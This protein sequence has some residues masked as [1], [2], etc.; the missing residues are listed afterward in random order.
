MP[1]AAIMP[2]FAIFETPLAAVAVIAGSA[3]IPIIIHLLNRKRFRI[4]TWAAM[5]FL[6]AAQKKNTRRMRIEQLVLLAV[7]TLI[8]LLLVCAMA[9]VMPWSESLWARLF[10][11]SAVRAAA[12]GRRT[13][14]ILVL[15]GSFS[16]AARVGDSTCFERARSAA[17]KLLQEAPAG[18]GFSVV[19]M[20]APPRRV[21]PEP[22][23]DARKA[24]EEVRALRLPHGNADLAAT[25]SA[26][27][28][29]VRHSPVKFEDREVYF[30]T[31]AQRSTW[32]ARQSGNTA[33]LL[34]KIQSRARTIL[35]DVGVEGLSNVAVTNLILGVPY[36]TTGAATPITAALHNYGSEVRGQLRVDLYIGKARA[37]ATD[38][39]F[40]FQLV[41]QSNV[42]LQPG[43]SAVNFNYQFTTPGD[44]ALQ[45]RLEN[46]ALELDDTRSVI[47][48]VKESVPVMLVNGK[49]ASELYDRATEWLFD[50]LNPFPSA[51]TPRNVPARPRTVTE[52]Q[53]ADA[54]LGDLSP[55][56]CVFLCDVP[57]LGAPEVR[58]LETHL[59]RG[60]GVVFCLGPRVDLESYNRL[61]YRNGEGI[62][63]ARLLGKQQA[64]DKRFFNFFAE[65]KTYHEPPL[66]A[67]AGER[68]RLSLLGARFTQYMRAELPSRGRARK[69]LSFMPEVSSASASAM[70]RGNG[71]PL[72]LG[73]P[74]VVEWSRYR[75]RVLLFTSTVNMDWTTWPISPS[76]PAMMQEL[77][78]FAVAG[79]LRE[80]AAVVGEPLRDFPQSAGAGLDVTVHTPEGRTETAHT[81]AHE[82]I[83]VLNWTDTDVSGV[84]RITI[85]QHP[86][87]YLFAV[88]V[89]TT[90]EVQSA[91]ES[92]L[93]RTNQ[94]ELQSAYPGWEFQLVT[95]LRDVVHTGGPA[96]E[97]SADRPLRGMGMI[98]ARWM[99]LIMVLL[100]VAEVVLAWRFG[101]YSAVNM[102]DQPPARGRLVPIAVAVV[103]GILFMAL[104]SVLAHAAWTGDFLSF[105]PEG[106]RASFEERLGIP[107][108]AAGEGTRWQ[109]EFTP[110]LWDAATDPWLAGGFALIMAIAII[111]IYRRE[112]Q[113]ANLVY[114]LLLG[115]LRMFFLLLTLAVLLPQ[116][117]L[118]F[119]REGW[120]DIAIVIDDSQSMS[121]TDRYQDARLQE[122]ATRLF[123]DFT[124]DLSAGLTPGATTAQRL[125]LAQAVLTNN[126]LEWLE[127]LL[128]H[129]RFKLH[130]YHCASR[131][132]RLADATEAHEL[133]AV[134][135]AIRQLRAEGDSSQLGTAVR[136]VLNDFRGSSLA[137]VIMFTDGVTTDGEDLLRV[138]HYATQ[139]G[140]PLFFVGIGD[141]H[142]TRDLKL[143]DVQVEDSVYV[144]DKLVFE[145]RVT[146]QGYSD[147]R[148]IP[149]ALFEK[150]K[151]G[152]LRPLARE[153]VA[154]DREGKPVKFR[155]I[156]QP[157]EPGE[158]TYVLAVPE[159]EDEVKPADNNRLERTVFV[160]EAK[161][162]KVLYIEGYARYEYR[163][164]KNL[165][166][167]ESDRDKKNKT[168]DLKVLLL[169][170]DDGYAAED[171]SAIPFFPIKEELNL[172]DV[173]IL[174]DVDPKDPKMGEKN[175][176]HLAAFV[177]E[178]GGGFLMIAGPRYTP[179][180]YKDSPLRDIMPIQVSADV[181]PD[182]D[183]QN[184]FRPEPTVV[185]RFHPIFRFSP[186]EAENTAIWKHLSEICWW[187]EGYRVQ[188]AAEVLLV[189]P[190]RPALDPRPTA[191]GEAGHPLLVQQFVGA[192]RS[193]FF[194]F[195]ETWRWRFREDE[196]RFNQFWIQTVR[197]LARSRLGRIDLRVDRQT[198]YRRGEPIKVSV[199][200]PDDVPPPAA[201]TKVE[202]VVTRTPIKRGDSAVPGELEKATLHLAKV[203]GSRATYEG[204]ITRTPEGEYHF[205]LA[206]PLVPDP[207]PRAE[208]RVLPPP[209]EMDLLRMNQPDM[210]RAAEETQGKF[211]TLADAD[212]L[213]DDLPSGTRITLSTPQP[214]RLLWNHAA[215]FALA[216]GLLSTEWLLRKRKHLL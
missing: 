52:S 64:P 95:D 155:L 28:D 55:Y 85:G 61:L 79:R 140:V 127:N 26:V 6:L 182:G 14:K 60:G 215:M 107:P 21:V 32:T 196:L 210:E 161:L 110:Y 111:V 132:A 9:S 186:D 172:F 204:L 88:N 59:H 97:V 69:I 167:R 156:H 198:P 131:A 200:F 16:M 175:L 18:D 37:G 144:N 199:R 151:A 158:K 57:R 211:Y 41:G 17:N 5:R 181:Q 51:Q 188:P 1:F 92:D 148:V 177:K 146:A 113:T 75:G 214:P 2:L 192:G 194:G 191:T 31:D 209:G 27:E 195:D 147:G 82:D 58:R 124:R 165:L 208:C 180:A 162:I 169:D 54:A 171:R 126:K 73:D 141:A 81:E 108:P 193:M 8:V 33:E 101:H 166:E 138:S 70:E 66:D 159:Q 201:D 72:P 118:L 176:Q 47:V 90:T 203:E 49:P 212:R 109:L 139:M 67:F 119:E 53:F 213:V 39:P 170:A 86:Q 71:L 78:H 83:G 23:D 112:G 43:Q 129:R 114:K 116:L 143:H 130:V 80:Q 117:R 125:Q 93:A 25:L 40:G 153:S 207:K 30:F 42:D 103:A 77:L 205:W 168:I 135:R 36:V 96:S 74:A 137:A 76:F 122:A 98:I 190:K 179:H 123:A 160:R 206:A 115:G 11:E 183:Y 56:D 38:P 157:T 121:T 174:G 133:D 145:G 197:Y 187:S 12:G 136:Q 48:T 128:T 99:L 102:I 65:E 202:V 19:L 189:H 62:L 46:D 15:D 50:A 149:V 44:Y 63:P 91:C 7:R 178:R 173:I 29:M 3:S 22:S 104:A 84:Y 150:D 105:L 89:P 4:V 24:A 106:M 87:D 152:N 35:V 10:P 154:T 20:A 184:G 120:P 34:Q 216:L 94:T 13:H 185:G 45:V 163:F 100:L 142:D 164:V 68:D 134:G